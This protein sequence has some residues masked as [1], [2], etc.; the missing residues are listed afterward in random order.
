MILSATYFDDEVSV[1]V[2]QQLDILTNLE[3]SFKKNKERLEV[4]RADKLVSELMD[5]DEM[6]TL[7]A[8]SSIA[9]TKGSRYLTFRL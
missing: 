4:V 2:K 7:Y 6:E 5:E 3:E 8:E 9:S 1:D